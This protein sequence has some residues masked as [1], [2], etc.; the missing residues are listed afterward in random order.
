MGKLID[1]FKEKPKYNYGCKN[2]TPNNIN[3]INNSITNRKNT[4]VIN[5]EGPCIMY[6]INLCNKLK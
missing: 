4:N 6:K 3:Y 5:Y 1:Q 2:Y